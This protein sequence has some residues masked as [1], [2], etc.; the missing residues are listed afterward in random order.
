[1]AW[2]LIN[3]MDFVTF[4]CECETRTKTFLNQLVLGLIPEK[5]KHPA[6]IA[7]IKVSIPAR[8]LP[9][10]PYVVNID[11]SSIKFK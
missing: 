10:L 11:F 3:I 9:E 8:C 7:F 5:G 1:M 6:V 4:S 2:T